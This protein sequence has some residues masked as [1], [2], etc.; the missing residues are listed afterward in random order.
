M[1]SDLKFVNISGTRV[2]FLGSSTVQLVLLCGVSGAAVV[3]LATMA[4]TW[5]GYREPCGNCNQ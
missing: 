4:D 5:A 2:D 3:P 1:V